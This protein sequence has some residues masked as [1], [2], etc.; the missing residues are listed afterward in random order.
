[1][2]LQIF[3]VSD[4]SIILYFIIGFDIACHSVKIVIVIIFFNNLFYRVQLF[5]VADFIVIFFESQRKYF[6]H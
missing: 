1:M 3:N 4:C 5:L 6:I 2:K